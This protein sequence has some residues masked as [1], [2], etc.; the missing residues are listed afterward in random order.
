MKTIGNNVAFPPPEKAV[1]DISNGYG[2]P[3]EYMGLTKREY[4]AV[5]AL[6]GLCADSSRNG[7][8]AKY[9]QSAVFFADA[10]IIELNKE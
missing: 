7:S 10:L 1:N 5:K 3:E 6:Q 9:A 4:F 8:E 2:Y